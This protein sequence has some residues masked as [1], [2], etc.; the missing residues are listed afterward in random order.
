M[1]IPV[2]ATLPHFYAQQLTVKLFKPL[3][4]M[5]LHTA[6]YICPRYSPAEKHAGDTTARFQKRISGP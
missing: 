3:N 4:D 2:V 1:S 5:R 6:D